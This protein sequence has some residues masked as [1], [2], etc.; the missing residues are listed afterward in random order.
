[1]QGQGS[2]NR[3]C[4]L[5]C[6]CHCRFLFNT[7]TF[8]TFVLGFLLARVWIDELLIRRDSFHGTSNSCRCFHAV[9][10]LPSGTKNKIGFID[11]FDTKA[12][13]FIDNHLRNSFQIRSA[14]FPGCRIHIVIHGTLQSKLRGNDVHQNGD[15]DARTKF[16]RKTG[17]AFELTEQLTGI[18]STTSSLRSNLLDLLVQ[19]GGR[20]S[21]FGQDGFRSSDSFMV[22]GRHQGFLFRF[23]L[24]D[25]GGIRVLRLLL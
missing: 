5:L 13:S 17:E 10:R 21:L 3:D 25:L 22:F 2:H 20:Q 24:L 23:Y 16:H 1:M 11:I 15:L 14:S 19:H 4:L 6:I 12:I 9:T 7:E 18:R 8:R